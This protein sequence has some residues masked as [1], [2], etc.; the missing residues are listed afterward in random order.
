MHFEILV[1]G[2]TEVIALNTLLRKI[3]GEKGGPHTWEI[4]KHGGIGE[5][6]KN[7]KASPDRRNGTLLHN[8]PSNLR[9]YGDAGRENEIVVVLLDL[10]DKQD[11][12][13]FKES[14]I[15][16]LAY[17][18]KQP[19]VLFRIAIEEL[20]AWYLGD[21]QAILQA[22]PKCRPEALDGYVQDSQCGTWELLAE[23]VHPGGLD[24]LLQHGKRSPRVLQEKQGWTRAICQHMDVENNQSPS[25]RAFRDGLRKFV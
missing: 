21:R 19:I 12:I 5:L 6:P 22:Y 1:E 17:C 20:E 15:N 9:A 10:D 14:L 13:A 4:H 2:Q 11:C 3:L 16:L 8:L 24:A 7:P 25:F 18:Q 23:A